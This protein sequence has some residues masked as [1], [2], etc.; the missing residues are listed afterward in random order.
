MKPYHL[1][2]GL[3]GG[4][5]FLI[6][7]DWTPDQ[8]LAVIE[9]LDDLRDRIWAHYELALFDLLRLRPAIFQPLRPELF[10]G[11]TKGKS[12]AVVGRSWPGIRVGQGAYRDRGSLGGKR[13]GSSG[14][15]KFL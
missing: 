12:H 8:A 5:D 3:G 15:Y 1:P 7:A 9:L 2:S 13:Q 14:S 11:E 6:C 10:R 4:L